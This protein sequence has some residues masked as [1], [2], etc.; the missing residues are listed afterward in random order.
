MK[1]IYILLALIALAAIAPGQAPQAEGPFEFTVR[2]M[3][4]YRRKAKPVANQAF[5]VLP[6]GQGPFAEPI[7]R[8][9]TDSEGQARV[10]IAR[11]R[12]QTTYAQLIVRLDQP[13][14]QKV[15]GRWQRG[16][17]RS[18][19]TPDSNLLIPKEGCSL[20]FQALD[21]S[22]DAVDA[23]FGWRGLGETK[24]GGRG[25]PFGYS[26]YGRGWFA[27]DLEEPC[28]V[29]LWAWKAGVGSAVLLGVEPSAV[30][31]TGQR[32][33][34][35]GEAA[36]QGIL[37]GVGGAGIADAPLFV[38]V[39]GSDYLP[40]LPFGMSGVSLG[41]GVS[42]GGLQFGS[43]QSDELGRFSIRGLM[44]GDYEVFVSSTRESEVKWTPL[45]GE[46]A[47]TS[48]E[49]NV[50]SFN[51]SVVRVRLLDHMGKT[52]SGS[53]VAQEIEQF[54]KPWEHFCDFTNW[55]ETP[56]L[57]VRELLSP[58]PTSLKTWSRQPAFWSLPNTL[59]SEVKPG[60]HYAVQVIGG[61]FLGEVQVITAPEDGTAITIEAK[62]GPIRPFGNL[63][64]ITKRRG[65]KLSD[66]YWSYKCGLWIADHETGVPLVTGDEHGEAP[67]KF[68]L[69]EGT[70]RVVLEGRSWNDSH[71]GTLTHS[72]DGGRAETI[73]QIK[74]G[75]EQTI[76][77]DMDRG[78]FLNIT[79]Q[80]QSTPADLAALCKQYKQTPDESSWLEAEAKK[81]H[82]RIQAP[83]RMPES[84]EFAGFAGGGTSCA[85]THLLEGWPI[86]ETHKSQMLPAGTYELVA[87]MPAGRELR[88]TIEIKAWGELDVLFD[89]Q[90]QQSK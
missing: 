74:S 46:L 28:A 25:N 78:G 89:F 76:E 29:D 16:M 71:H 50:L 24:I 21:E 32:L 38:R 1:P 86:G 37:R 61:A 65:R 7:A 8:G 49:Q 31:E 54:S 55:P 39:K 59:I 18:M 27:A 14:M 64:I 52:W 75:A 34:L 62:A 5:I 88:K 72:R 73:V 70:Y 42:T 40:R 47:S 56:Q 20:F 68:S 90:A 69:P 79:I 67:P 80:G 85:G 45:L 81:A 4:S 84:V 2:T 58:E 15:E 26:K 60:S 51:Q 19:R 41:N 10:S 13:G 82:L 12:V 83:K 33:T 77:L 87:T 53:R 9:V 48:Q 3:T 11:H 63:E 57:I 6:R 35:K 66:E 43:C 36:L 30:P 17:S 23:R 22:G 44:E